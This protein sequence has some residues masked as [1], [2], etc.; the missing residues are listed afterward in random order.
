MSRALALRGLRL[1]AACALAAATIVLFRVWLDP[2]DPSL[3]LG[4]WIAGL[5]S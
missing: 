4:A 2:R 1:L 5:C 3:W